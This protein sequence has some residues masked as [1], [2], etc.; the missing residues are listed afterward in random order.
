MFPP[1][2]MAPCYARCLIFGW[3]PTGCSPCGALTR[4]VCLSVRTERS[5]HMVLPSPDPRSPLPCQN[6]RIVPAPPG[7]SRLPDCTVTLKSGLLWWELHLHFADS[8][9]NIDTKPSGLNQWCHSF[10]VPPGVWYQALDNALAETGGTAVAASL[11]GRARACRVGSLVLP[12]LQSP[13]GLVSLCTLQPSYKWGKAAWK[14]VET[15]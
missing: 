6:S 5:F 15:A 1:S 14:V 13:G 9:H 3:P 2:L 7:W 4:V 10:M 12:L 11:R 8:P